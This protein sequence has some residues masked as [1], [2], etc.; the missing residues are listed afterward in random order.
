[1]ISVP[2]STGS[3]PLPTAPAGPSLPPEPYLMMAAAQM[4]REGRL[5]QSEYGE[6]DSTGGKE[7]TPATPP[8]EP[9]R[10]YFPS[11]GRRDKPSMMT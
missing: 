2:A 6:P 1:M 7:P 9:P 4:H 3:A 8:Q 10:Q 11:D 5:V